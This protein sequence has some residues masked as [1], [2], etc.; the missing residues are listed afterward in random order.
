MSARSNRLGSVSRAG[1]L[2]LGSFVVLQLSLADLAHAQQPVPAEDADITL[3]RDA[4]SAYARSQAAYRLGTRRVADAE[5]ALVDSLRGDR[6]AN[7]RAECALALGRLQ[8]QAARPALENAVHDS[9]E[10]DA[11]RAAAAQALEAI[12]TGIP[13]DC[14]DTHI[15]LVPSPRGDIHLYRCPHG[16][17]Y[18]GPARPPRH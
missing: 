3:L 2:V 9:E 7:V 17:T 4:P 14:H 16:E 5:S 13:M 1:L 15:V 8:A 18:Q 12:D 10:T 6:S 11:V